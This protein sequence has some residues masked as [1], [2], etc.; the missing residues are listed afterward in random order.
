MLKFL[1]LALL[2]CLSS[3]F[4]V[5]MLP[6]R[7]SDLHEW[8]GFQ[9]RSV[10]KTPA[11]G[12]AISVSYLGNYLL[13]SKGVRTDSVFI[14]PFP[15]PDTYNDLQ[16]TFELRN[17]ESVADLKDSLEIRFTGNG[18]LVRLA[19]E[20]GKFR[21]LSRQCDAGKIR[22][23][24]LAFV[25]GADSV[26]GE[27]QNCLC[28]GSWRHYRKGVL[29]GEHFFNAQGFLDGPFFNYDLSGMP[30]L[31]LLSGQYKANQKTGKWTS[32]E[33]NSGTVT[34]QELEYDSLGRTSHE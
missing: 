7:D 33:L 28:Q 19:Y 14:D 5:T 6:L 2:C 11:R 31:W 21:V 22:Q 3:C 20:N 8:Q 17:I 24:I 23:N 1:A 29:V 30:D 9:I 15:V 27:V 26:S 4:A 16:E 10:L 25:R 12:D 13:F 18:L 32:F 34:V